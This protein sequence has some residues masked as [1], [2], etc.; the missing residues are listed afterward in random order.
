MH[1]TNTDVFNVLAVISREIK[2]S[3]RIRLKKKTLKRN[4]IINEPVNVCVVVVDLTTKLQPGLK[5]F[6][7]LTCFIIM[8]IKFWFFLLCC[9]CKTFVYLIFLQ[10]FRRTV[11]FCWKLFTCELSTSRFPVNFHS[12]RGRFIP[13]C[14]RTT[15]N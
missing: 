11:K 2:L 7:L 3:Q 6:I 10:F 8:T 15:F 14:G 4:I 1:Q 12:G 9:L 5:Q 13:F